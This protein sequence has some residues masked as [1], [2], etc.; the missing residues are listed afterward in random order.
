M[1]WVVE[2]SWYKA[3][4]VKEA[5]QEQQPSME[6]L[7]VTEGMLII[8]QDLDPV[9]LKLSLPSDIETRIKEVT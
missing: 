2:T 1:V 9:L 3:D 5:L 4:D 6:V 8:E 7:K